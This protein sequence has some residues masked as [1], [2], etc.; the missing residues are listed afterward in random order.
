MSKKRMIGQDLEVSELGYGCM[1]ITHASGAPMS[2]K[3]GVEVIRNAVDTGYTLFD[4]AECY[5]GVYPDGS[6]AYNED[7]VGEALHDIRDQVVIASKFGVVHAGDHLVMNST[8]EVIRKSV[9]GSLKRLKTDY[10]DIYYQHRIDPNVEPE[11]VASVMKELIKEGKIRH[12]GISEVNEEYLRRADA[13]CHVSVIE[14][15]YSMMARWYESLFPTLEELNISFVAYSPIANGFLSGK[16][17]PDTKFEK[18]ADFRS[19]MP[20]YTKEGYEKDAPLLLML[21]KM[22]EEKNATM[23]Q[24]S[25][26]W[27]LSKKP[28]IIPIPGTRKIERMRENINS[29]NIEL[30][31][32]EVAQIDAQLDQMDLSVFGGHK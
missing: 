10:L 12:W 2:T 1:G 3:E 26:A 6:I 31:K 25:L 28:Y 23:A 24:L 18:G 13:V 19:S 17:T 8:P 4:T 29:A 11:V 27:M 22:A 5:Q 16:Y 30:S 14:N 7:V 21:Q 20:Q 9:E 32:E 15:R